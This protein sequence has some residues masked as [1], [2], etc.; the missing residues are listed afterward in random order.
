MR[1]RQP[2]AVLPGGSPRIHRTGLP[3]QDP[4]DRLDRK[5]YEVMISESAVEELFSI[6][7]IMVAG[8]PGQIRL[9]SLI[10]ISEPTRH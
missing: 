5:D 2:R 10:H 7:G 4:L 1:A 8:H 6:E 3:A 9:L